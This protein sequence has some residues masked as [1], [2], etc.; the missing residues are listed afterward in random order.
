M[1]T[2]SPPSALINKPGWVTDA[3]NV[4][5]GLSGG[6]DKRNGFTTQ[7]SS[8][9]GSRDISFGIE[10]KDSAATRKTILFGTDGTAAGG[11]FGYV[12]AGA[13]TDIL[14][15]L[16]G[17][18][19]PGFVQFRDLLFFFNGV[20]TPKVYDG[21]NTRQVGITGPAAAPSITS[22]TTAGS[23]TLLGSYVF[24]YT[25]YNSVTKAEST[26]SPAST[27]TALTGVNNKFVLGLVAGDA[28]TADTIR[29]WSTV[30]N[31]NQA[32]LEGTTGISST[33]YNAIAADSALTTALEFDNTRIT[34]LSTT[35]KV[36]VHC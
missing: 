5:L 20:D 33:S 27:S 11:R 3:R 1:D 32:F 8:A 13:V 10:Y 2:T 18:T 31:G 4:N 36:S 28:T 14:T 15:G 17:T 19:R 9:W 34:S 25:Y 12:S 21:T 6:Y 26:P 29:I 7:L 24:F 22:Q 16:S 23:K 35:A 30:A